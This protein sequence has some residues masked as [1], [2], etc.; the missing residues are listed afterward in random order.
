MKQHRQ[1]KSQRYVF[2]RQAISAISISNSVILMFLL[3]FIWD[4]SIAETGAC[5]TQSNFI[6]ACSGTCTLNQ[7][8]MLRN[9]CIIIYNNFLNK[10]N[11]FNDQIT[12]DHH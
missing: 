3:H 7:F 11:N 2:L 6:Y 5:V 9:L 10:H 12:D 1:L 8:H 4:R